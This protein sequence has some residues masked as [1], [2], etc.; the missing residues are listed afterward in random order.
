METKHPTT[1]PPRN[2]G[3]AQKRTAQDKARP[4]PAHSEEAPPARH[5][6]VAIVLEI[7]CLSLKLLEVVAGFFRE[8]H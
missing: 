8:I 3:R 7:T 4:P 6:Q 2:R 5:K 1:G